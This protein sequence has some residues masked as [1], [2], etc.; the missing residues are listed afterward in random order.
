MSNC[1]NIHSA[2]LEFSTDRQT[3]HRCHVPLY[4]FCCDGA[5]D[6]PDK[7]LLLQV[8]LK[9]CFCSTSLTAVLNT[10]NVVAA[11]IPVC[12]VVLLQCSKG[13]YINI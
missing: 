7:I 3:W 5:T 6:T 9:I 11:Q 10:G 12:I 13:A 1:M 2:V 8:K 4:K